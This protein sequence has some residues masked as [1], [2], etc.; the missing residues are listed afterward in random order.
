MTQP[1]QAFEWRESRGD[2][3]RS[4]VISIISA[5]D[6]DCELERFFG[7]PAITR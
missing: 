5:F 6:W 4:S 2:R 1:S 3:E 7:F